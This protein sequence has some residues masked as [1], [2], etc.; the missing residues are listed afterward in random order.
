MDMAEEIVAAQRAE[1]REEM[2]TVAPRLAVAGLPQVR[3][4]ILAAPPASAILEAAR[5]FDSHLVVM[6]AHGRSGIGRVLLGSV[7]D[8]IL[9]RLDGG[10]VLLVRPLA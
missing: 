2:A 6:A 8:E 1:A 5:R 9:R 3:V 4:E 7:A 10:A